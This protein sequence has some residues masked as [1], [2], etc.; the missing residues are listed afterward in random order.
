LVGTPPKVRT[1]WSP[2]NPDMVADAAETT[3]AASSWGEGSSFF[4]LL[5]LLLRKERWLALRGARGGGGG[6]GRARGGVC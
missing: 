5:V 3:L 4:A 6:V 1:D 2:V